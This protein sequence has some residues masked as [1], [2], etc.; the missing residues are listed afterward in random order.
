MQTTTPNALSKKPFR[1]SSRSCWQILEYA[2]IG[3]KQILCR[4]A[5][6]GKFHFI[7]TGNHET[8]LTLH[9][10]VLAKEDYVNLPGVKIDKELNFKRHVNEVC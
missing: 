3:L 1:E 6:L 4:L 9:D 5:N 7:L 10:V 8:L 2:L